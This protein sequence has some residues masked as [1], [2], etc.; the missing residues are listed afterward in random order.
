MKPVGFSR[1]GLQTLALHVAAYA[2]VFV[3]I[4]PFVWMVISAFKDKAVVNSLP[5]RL[6]FVPTLENFRNVIAQ[7]KFWDYAVNSTVV[8]VGSTLLGSVLGV[9]AAYSIARY[10]QQRLAVFVLLAR[11][12]P[13]ISYLVPWFIVFTKLQIMGTYTAMILT[14]LTIVL[15][16]IIWV[17]I[18]FFEDLPL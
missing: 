14:H 1:K 8:A 11:I 12:L 4:F 7:A 9:P 16:L 15:P 10:R 13:G 3:F 6:L 5:P 17:M 2:I 18:G